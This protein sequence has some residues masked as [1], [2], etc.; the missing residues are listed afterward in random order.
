MTWPDRAASLQMRALITAGLDPGDVLRD[1]L[2]EAASGDHISVA[3]CL[4]DFVVDHTC[5][6]P[7]V[8]LPEYMLDFVT[9]AAL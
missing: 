1:L 3:L 6:D 8:G 9:K 4:I 5:V 2:V 7:G